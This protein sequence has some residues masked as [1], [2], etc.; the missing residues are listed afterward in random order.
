M[1]LLHL[2]RSAPLCAPWSTCH[3]ARSQSHP[4]SCSTCST[5]PHSRSHR[6]CILSR[7]P[8]LKGSRPIP[9]CS[10]QVA[11]QFLGYQSL[12]QATSFPS[13]DAT[14]KITFPKC[15]FRVLV[16]Y[17][18]AFT[19]W[20]SDWFSSKNCKNLKQW[21]S[22]AGSFTFQGKHPC[23]LITGSIK[24]LIVVWEPHYC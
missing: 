23:L 5:S 10:S 24:F 9:S 14:L 2:H 8:L 20:Q 6:D 21:Y 16:H 1:S 17:L 3:S 12:P 13:V 19:K 18:F 7:T 11:S 4:S 15:A 22:Q